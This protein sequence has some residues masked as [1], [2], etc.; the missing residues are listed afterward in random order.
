MSK[1]LLLTTTFNGSVFVS[2]FTIFKVADQ[3][4]VLTSLAVV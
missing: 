1:L 3:E 4:M 2:A